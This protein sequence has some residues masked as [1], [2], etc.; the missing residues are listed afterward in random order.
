M[1]FNFL[2]PYLWIIKREDIKYMKL[3]KIMVHFKKI[4]QK[5][6]KVLQKKA[7][8]LLMSLIKVY[9]YLYLYYKVQKDQISKRRTDLLSRK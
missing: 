1:E 8:K 4:Y 6:I 5:I 9:F 7:H 3:S 2:Y